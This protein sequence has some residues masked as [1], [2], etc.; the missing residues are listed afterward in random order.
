M[1]CYGIGAR[2]RGLIEEYWAGQQMA[3]HQGGYYGQAF[4]PGRGVTQGDFLSPTLFNLVVDWV[5]RVVLREHQ[6]ELG[7]KELCVFYADDGY[8]ES[9]EFELVQSLSES[10]I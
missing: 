2:L 5:L 8:W 9:H 6:F 3:V 4:E 1:R 7:V 10:S